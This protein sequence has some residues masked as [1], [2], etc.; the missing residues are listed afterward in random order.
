V[1]LLRWTSHLTQRPPHREQ[2]TRGRGRPGVPNSAA[3]G[4]P[5]RPY[6]QK[7]IH[8]ELGS[9]T[10]IAAGARLVPR[11][12][13]IGGVANA[14]PMVSACLLALFSD[15]RVTGYTGLIL[16]IAVQEIVLAIWLLIK[17]YSSSP[18]STGPSTES[19]TAL[20]GTTATVC[21]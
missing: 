19:P 15:S 10:A 2:R 16:P 4:S 20:N 17:G 21:T 12:L 7:G 18:H 11:W 8:R 14:L 5:R 9:E 1:R 6:F 13:S 3:D